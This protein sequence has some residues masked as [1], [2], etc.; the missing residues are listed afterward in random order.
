V[1]NR[2]PVV[3]IYQKAYDIVIAAQKKPA[4]LQ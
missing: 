1:D 3:E 4:P 2:E